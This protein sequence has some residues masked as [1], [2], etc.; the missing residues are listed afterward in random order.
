M[1]PFSYHVF[2]CEQRKPEGLPCCSARG[3]LAVIEALRREVGARGLLDSVAV[4]TCGSLGMCENGPNLVVYPEGVWYSHVTPADVPE[5]VASHFQQGR[6]LER[7]MRRDE[8][9]L[10]AE[11]PATVPRE[12]PCCG[13]A[14]PPGRSPTS[15]PTPSAATCRAVWSSPPSSSTSSP[16]WGAGRPG[17]RQSPPR[18][19]PICAPPPSCSTPWGPSA[20]SRSRRA[21]TPTRQPPPASSR[22]GARTTP[23][24]P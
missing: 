21:P 7:L 8:A 4:T 3:S 9:A 11:S 5:L 16:R 10:K 23:A 17:R 12:W 22:R 19:A 14:T 6:P 24:P 13:P 20:S 2:A 18:W 1:H 15:S